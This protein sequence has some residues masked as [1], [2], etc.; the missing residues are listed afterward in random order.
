MPWEVD[1]AFNE[2]QPSYL[3]RQQRLQFWARL[4]ARR[5]LLS[6]LVS[7]PLYC[8]IFTCLL[9]GVAIHF[10]LIR[11]PCYGRS[12]GNPLIE[13]AYYVMAGFPLNEPD[14][15]VYRIELGRQHPLGQRSFSSDTILALR[16]PLDRPLQCGA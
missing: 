5:R 3:R 4:R 15:L 11:P 8:L 9:L 12:F 13:P 1:T 2:Q 10:S 7:L 14:P 16:I 6:P